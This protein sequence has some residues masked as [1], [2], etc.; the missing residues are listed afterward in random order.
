MSE[1]ELLQ[2]Y[3]QRLNAYEWTCK[4]KVED[5]LAKIQR[6]DILPKSS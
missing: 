6:K 4:L 1:Q 3:L 5:V 2:N